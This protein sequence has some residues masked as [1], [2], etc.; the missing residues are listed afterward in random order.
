VTPLATDRYQITFTASAETR[1]KLQLAQD[2]LRHTIPSGDAAAIIDRALTVLLEDLAREKFAA[3]T[4][5]RASRG[6]AKGSRD[7]PASVMRAVRVRGLGRCAFVSND[8]RRCNERGFVEFHHVVPHG[9]GG[10]PTVSNLEL[11]CESHNAYEADLYYGPRAPEGVVCESPA[12]YR[13]LA[14]Q[15]NSVRT[16]L[17]RR[18]STVLQ[19][20]GHLATEVRLASEPPRRARLVDAVLPAGAIPNSRLATT[21]RPAVKARTED[22]S[23]DADLVRPPHIGIRRLLPRRSAP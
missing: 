23:V 1:E 8:G 11:R 5:P 18:R 14:R 4:H 22:H 3:T 9:A 10:P 19:G 16:E 6:T 15:G 12:P 20:A 17:R 13:T 7:I 21:A 2:L